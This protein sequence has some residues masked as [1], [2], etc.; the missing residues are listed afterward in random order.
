[1]L[2]NSVFNGINNNLSPSESAVLSV[3][4]SSGNFNITS[5]KF[6]FERE[7]ALD[8]NFTG[9]GIYLIDNNGNFSINSN[10]FNSFANGSVIYGENTNYI[11]V[12]SSNV[13]FRSQGLSPLYDRFL[14]LINSKFAA[15]EFNDI[16]VSQGHSVYFNNVDSSRVFFNYFGSKQNDLAINTGSKQSGLVLSTESSNNV[17][18]QNNFL[19]NNDFGIIDSSNNNTIGVNYF[20]C[21]GSGMINSPT[22]NLLQDHFNNYPDEYLVNVN[23]TSDSLVL[24]NLPFEDGTKV[25]IYKTL[26]C[27]N[28]SFESNELRKSFADS[29]TIING[30]LLYEIA[31][32]NTETEND[33]SPFKLFFVGNN[34]EIIGTSKRIIYPSTVSTQ[35]VASQEPS[36]NIFPN[37]STGS[38]NIVSEKNGEFSIFDVH[39]KLVKRSLIAPNQNNTIVISTPG[40]YFIAI[41]QNGV[42]HKQK[43]IIN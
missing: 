24:N 36:I 1:M 43:I 27:Q 10:I 41:K 7:I 8:G 12:N 28:F 23:T 31:G 39:G 40:V 42:H 17:I 13:G 30:Q 35:N 6:G 15:I 19:Y 11:N 9:H 18:K 34:G 4:N 2:Q 14:T 25:Y 22:I 32:S 16:G 33:L 21:N 3:T 5:N 38:I 37:P 20:V 29:L 26:N